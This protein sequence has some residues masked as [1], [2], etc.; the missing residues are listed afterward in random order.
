MNEIVYWGISSPFKAHSRI[1]TPQGI[2]LV[3]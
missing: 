2:T 3:I 1:I